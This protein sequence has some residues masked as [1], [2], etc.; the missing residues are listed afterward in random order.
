MDTDMGERQSDGSAPG[1]RRVHPG[2]TVSGTE[3]WPAGPVLEGLLADA[4]CSGALDADAE[5]RAVAAFRAARDAGA[6][7]TRTRRRDDWRPREHGRA[8]RSL[9]TTLT[10][11]LA[12][13]TLGGVAYATI[14]SVGGS[15]HDDGHGARQRQQTPAGPSATDSRTPGASAKPDRP[16]TAKDT[17]AH[18][19]A[20]EKKVDG[21]GKALDSTAWQRLIAAAGGEA[22]VRA[23]CAEQLGA[24]TATAKPGK[25]DRTA[26]ADKT[27]KPQKHNA[28]KT[29]GKNN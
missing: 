27:E 26:K 21:D 1:R 28:D 9:R 19:R 20:Y 18:C 3:D 8:R 22:N 11:A 12:G 24:A 25:V 7:R 4:M 5:Q 14:G 16:E 2:G 29:T 15:S 17:E 13:L 23:Y 10:L 6:H